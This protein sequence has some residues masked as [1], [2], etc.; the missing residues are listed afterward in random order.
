[1]KVEY[2]EATGQ[3]TREAKRL[4]ERCV[5][6]CV[7]GYCAQSFPRQS[8]QPN[9][10]RQFQSPVCGNKGVNRCQG[11]SQSSLK[12]NY[13]FIRNRERDRHRQREKQAPCREPNVGLDPWTPGPHPEPKAGTKP[14]NHPEIPPELLMEVRTRVQKGNLHCLKYSG[15]PS[16]RVV[17]IEQ[18]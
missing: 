14:L 15:K 12:K 18:H 10:Y 3:T 16:L 7:H 9:Q 5:G 8:L 1:M 4:H 13:L 6:R 17:K 11:S 2:Q